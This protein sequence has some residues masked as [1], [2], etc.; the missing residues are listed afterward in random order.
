MLFSQNCF[1][2]SLLTCIKIVNPTK[3][4]AETVNYWVNRTLHAVH[5]HTLSLS[6]LWNVETDPD[7]TPF[8]RIIRNLR[9]NSYCI[10][11]AHLLPT[12]P[13]TSTHHALYCS[14]ILATLCRK[15]RLL[16]AAIALVLTSSSRAMKHSAPP[17]EGP[18]R[19]A[20]RWRSDVNTNKSSNKREP[21]GQFNLH[22][23]TIGLKV[24]N[25]NIHNNNWSLSAEGNKTTYKLLTSGARD[26]H[27][28]DV[29]IRP[30]Q[31]L[32]HLL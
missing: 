18:A 13:Y 28:G 4:T 7:Y 3:C 23:P 27:A 10:K 26:V 16:R 11:I 30:L 15:E 2:F 29:H 8:T 12:V 22:L 31:D 21:C 25:N 14:W 1:C 17:P 20:W 5:Y 19:E 9:W 32:Q 24:E 6:P